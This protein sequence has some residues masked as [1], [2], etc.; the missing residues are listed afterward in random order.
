MTALAELRAAA[1]HGH[2]LGLAM[3]AGHGLTYRN[4]DPGRGD[5]RSSRS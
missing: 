5:S 4:V 3:H 2:G 1:R